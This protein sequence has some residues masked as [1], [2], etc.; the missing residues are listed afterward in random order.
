MYHISGIRVDFL[1][2]IHQKVF[3]F[4]PQIEDKLCIIVIGI[5]DTKWYLLCDVSKPFRSA[6]T[7]VF[8]LD[9]IFDISFRSAISWPSKGHNILGD[10]TLDDIASSLGDNQMLLF[11]LSPYFKSAEL[12]K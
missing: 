12:L 2:A 10:G 8:Q 5:E 4:W 1:R 7:G 6:R 9:K 3:E 11:S